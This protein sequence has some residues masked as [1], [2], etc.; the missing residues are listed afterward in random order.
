MICPIW[1]PLYSTN[2]RFLSGP[3]VIATGWLLGVFTR[4]SAIRPELHR[5]R[6]ISK[7]FLA[8]SIMKDKSISE[9]AREISLSPPSHLPTDSPG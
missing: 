7:T 1:F 5:S 9:D 8:M 2:Q 3:A 6:R 4:N